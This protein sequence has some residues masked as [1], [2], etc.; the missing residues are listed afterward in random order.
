MRKANKPLIFITVV[1]VLILLVWSGLVLGKINEI[2]EESFTEPD[3]PAYIYHD[4]VKQID[5]GIESFYD[6]SSA[7][8]N[9]LQSSLTRCD[10][11]QDSYEELELIPLGDFTITAY[12]AGFESCVKLPDDPLYGQPKISGST[13]VN[14]ETVYVKENYTIASDW[15]VI[16]PLSKVMIEGLPYIYTVEDGGP[17]IVGNRL[18]LYIPELVDAQEWGVQSRKVYLV[19]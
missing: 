10:E 7:I 3:G 1:I 17:A 5:P 19:K 16:P 12:T 6:D 8:L 15:S 4:G 11:L 13:I 18:D 2:S 14:Y 9:S